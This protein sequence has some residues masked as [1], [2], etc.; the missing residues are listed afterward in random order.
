MSCSMGSCMMPGARKV[1]SSWAR[2]LAAFTAKRARTA[3]TGNQCLMTVSLLVDEESRFLRLD[4]Q[5]PCKVYLVFCGAAPVVFESK[6]RLGECSNQSACPYAPAVC[7]RAHPQYSLNDT[8]GICY[9]VCSHR[10]DGCL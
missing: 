6:R 8:A 1:I 2:A 9:T 4:C 3:I 7:F 10:C 5:I